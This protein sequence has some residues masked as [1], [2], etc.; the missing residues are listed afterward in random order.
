MKTKNL[1]IFGIYL[2]RTV[3]N[4]DRLFVCVEVLHYCDA[5]VPARELCPEKPY[6]VNALLVFDGDEVKK[7]EMMK[8]LS[9]LSRGSYVELH[10]KDAIDG[11]TILALSSDDII[12]KQTPEIVTFARLAEE[13]DEKW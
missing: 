7:E 10:V 1:T 11:G 12:I 4:P 2:G 5:D 6:R 8:T 13:L 3:A 9:L